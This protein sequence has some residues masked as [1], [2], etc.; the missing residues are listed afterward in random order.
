[1]SRQR[2]AE[3]L[4]HFSQLGLVL[5]TQA[6]A[7]VRIVVHLGL[8]HFLPEF[9]QD[10]LLFEKRVFHVR[11]WF[12]S[13]LF[14]I[15]PSLRLATCERFS[16]MPSLEII[17]PDFLR[18]QGD[19]SDTVFSES[20]LDRRIVVVSGRSVSCVCPEGDVS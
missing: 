13:Q 1:M 8:R 10:A 5:L 17:V 2:N 6:C 14:Q 15:V 3:R 16:R 7:Y 18:L 19:F 9:M 20:P 12:P 11:S 4:A